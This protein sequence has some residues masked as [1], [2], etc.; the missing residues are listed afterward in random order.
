MKLLCYVGRQ[1]KHSVD[2]QL[3]AD[4]NSLGRILKQGLDGVYQNG[5]L[6]RVLKTGQPK[7]GNVIY[8]QPC[9]EGV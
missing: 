8:S 2:Y 6:T 7:C 4:V 9:L 3:E 5:G 1:V